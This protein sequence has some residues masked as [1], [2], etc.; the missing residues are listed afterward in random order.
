MKKI[1]EHLDFYKWIYILIISFVLCVGSLVWYE[2]KYPC[3][4]GHYEQQWQSDYMYINGNYQYVGG[5]YESVFVCDCRE[6]R[7]N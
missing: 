2:Y 4:K 5:H 6:K 7:N 3:I 1:I